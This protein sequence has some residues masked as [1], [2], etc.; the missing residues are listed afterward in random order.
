MSSCSGFRAINHADTRST[1]GLAVT[2][3]GGVNCAR[4]RMM[5]RVVDLQKGEQ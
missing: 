2:G 5:L 1:K 4:H 3:V